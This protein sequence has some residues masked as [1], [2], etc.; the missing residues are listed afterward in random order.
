MAIATERRELILNSVDL[1]VGNEIS[2]YIEPS[3]TISVRSVLIPGKPDENHLVVQ[4]TDIELDAVEHIL[5]FCQKAV[6]DGLY[7]PHIRAAIDNGTLL[8][9]KRNAA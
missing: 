6:A 5:D 3:R 9:T 7:Q 8:P 4:G 2:L 1:E